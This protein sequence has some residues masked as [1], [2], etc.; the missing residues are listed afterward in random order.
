MKVF[1]AGAKSITTLDSPVIEKMASIRAKGIH[2]LVGDCYGVD[3]EVQRFYSDARYK[4]VDV[5]ASNGKAR[6][7]IGL[8][9]VVSVSVPDGVK[10]YKFYRCKDIAMA[11][12]ADLGLMVW[13]GR[14]KGTLSNAITMVAKGKTVLIYMTTL[15]RM[16]AVNN[17]RELRSLVAL[18]PNE[19]RKLFECTTQCILGDENQLAFL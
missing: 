1:I 16:F 7:N 5:Y 4:N 19:T 8:W 12:D 17:L 13:D 14:S 15:K 18:C 6:N 9:N 11:Q 3:S 10:G 2:V